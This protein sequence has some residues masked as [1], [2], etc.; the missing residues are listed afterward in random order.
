MQFEI[1]KED[2]SFYDKI[3]PIFTWVKYSIPTPT[4]CPDC[5]QQRRLAFR[6]ESNLS[7]R[8][9]TASWK[10]IISMYW[11]NTLFPVYDNKFWWSDNWDWKKFWQDIDFNK[12]FTEQFLEIFN[13]VPKM[14]RI[15]QWDNE[16]STYCNCMSYNKNCYLIFTADQNENCYYWNWIDKC[17]NCIDNLT[18]SQCENIYE[19]VDCSNCYNIQY[20][21]KVHNSNNSYYSFDCRNC[22]NIFACSWLR[23]KEYYILNKKVSKEEFVEILNDSDKKKKVL[24]KYK[25]LDSKI[26]RLY[27]D[28]LNS[29]NF[30]GSY[31]DNSKNAFHCWDVFWLEDCKYCSDLRIAKNCYDI[32]F[33]WCTSNNELLYE[34]EAVGHWASNV[35]FSK[36]V[37]WWSNDILYCYECFWSNNLFWCTWLKK[38]K[39]CIFNKQYTKQEYELIVPKIIEHM[40]STWEWWEFFSKQLS[41]FAYNECISNDHFPISEDQAIEIWFKWKNIKEEIPL[42]SKL[43]PAEKLPDDIKD[44]PD[45]ILNWAVK[46]EITW[47]PFKIIPEELKFYRQH[48]ISIPHFH[49]NERHKMRFKKRNPR[50][51]YDRNC[52]KCDKGM[53]T[54]YAPDREEMVYCED[55]YLKEVY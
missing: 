55:C 2:L 27:S 48:N 30:S 21:Q 54:T 26:P 39:Y 45:D 32:N 50:K 10:N 18:I 43:L 42:V 16:N 7:K 53:Q 29:E 12:T 3:S 44:V 17:K 24:S 34:C 35:L 31:V 5:R 41:P 20:C 15:Q 8:K 46:C 40:K 25:D 52:K 49:P 33:Y 14:A 1:T 11:E 38:S 36:L 23:N 19:C 37:W 22:R 51:L 28:F 9:C 4:F 13:K 6:N 47:K